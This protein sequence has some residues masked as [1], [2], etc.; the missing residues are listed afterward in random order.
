FKVEYLFQ[1]NQLWQPS[2]QRFLQR[3]IAIFKASGDTA[4]ATLSVS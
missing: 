3:L 2:S 1:L 4:S